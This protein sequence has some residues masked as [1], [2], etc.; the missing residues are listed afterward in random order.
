M[1]RLSVLVC[2]S[3]CS[4]LRRARIAD[5]F[6]AYN[7]ALRR[8]KFDINGR[9]FVARFLKHRLP[10]IQFRDHP[11]QPLFVINLNPGEAHLHI[12]PQLLQLSRGHQHGFSELGGV[13][14]R[15]LHDMLEL[16]RSLLKLAESAAE[17][18]HK[19]IVR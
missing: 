10:F 6:E 18:F 5:F 9:K 15:G 14:W 19:I 2:R 17:L 3:E 16:R 1:Q 11:R 12:T 13:L 4:Q 7:H 8:T